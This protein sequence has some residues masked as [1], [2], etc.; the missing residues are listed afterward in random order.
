[1]RKLHAGSRLAAALGIE[2]APVH[3]TPQD[4]RA[5]DCAWAPHSQALA[6][7]S[8]KAH[9]DIDIIIHKDDWRSGARG[10]SLGALS[11]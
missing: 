8:F 2:V 7:I 3:V 9:S 6:A 11:A 10:A 1:M 5:R 4:A